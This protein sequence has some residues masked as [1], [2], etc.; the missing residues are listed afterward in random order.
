MG[1]RCCGVD[2]V[3]AFNL[4]LCLLILTV[5]CIVY[6]RTKIKTPFHIGVAFG[7]FAVSH[8]IALFGVQR[9][10]AVT[11]MLIR[12]FAYLIVLFSLWEM[13]SGVK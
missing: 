5:G 2:V 13:R 1:F 7:L 6:A 9:S 8:V 11:I 3:N 10:F 12:V 4:A